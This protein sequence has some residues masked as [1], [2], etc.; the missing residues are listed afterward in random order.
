MRRERGKLK[1]TNGEKEEFLWEPESL[2]ARGQPACRLKKRREGCSNANG[3]GWF[4]KKP[5]KAGPDRTG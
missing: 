3:V 2:P 4:I 5:E 1:K